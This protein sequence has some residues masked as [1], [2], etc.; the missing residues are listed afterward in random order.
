MLDN[1]H[2]CS[3]YFNYNVYLFVF[4]KRG[5]VMVIYLF[6]LEDGDVTVVVVLVIPRHAPIIKHTQ[7][8]VYMSECRGGLGAP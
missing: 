6:L 1:E 8:I 7:Y 3:S 2:Q 5:D 4:Q